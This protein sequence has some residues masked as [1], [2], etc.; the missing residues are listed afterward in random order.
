MSNINKAT[1]IIG[2][3]WFWYK[4]VLSIIS[5]SHILAT[6]SSNDNISL[7]SHPLH[8]YHR[9]PNTCWRDN[10]NVQC[11][12]ICIWRDISGHFVSNRVIWLHYIT[13]P[14]HVGSHTTTIKIMLRTKLICHQLLLL[15]I[16]HRL[17]D[18]IGSLNVIYE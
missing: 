10:G 11:F 2:G 13:L 6:V 9:H 15:H 5:K 3:V 8:T 16:V 7:S 1:T 4:I 12:I 18:K 17:V 14:G